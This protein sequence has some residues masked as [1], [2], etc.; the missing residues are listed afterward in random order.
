MA[1]I[2]FKIIGILLIAL[3]SVHAIFPKYF[4]WKQDLKSLTLINRQM[5]IVHTF[6]IALIVLLMGILCLIAT[7]ELIQTHLGKTISLGLGIFWAIRLC[8]QCFGYSPSL[9]KG[10]PFETTMHILFLIF[11]T[12]LTVVFLT[13]AL[14]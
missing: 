10:K 12:Y 1:E 3:A 5:M 9:W 4:D 11:W 13:N 7:T 2:H 6:F 8:I 14:S